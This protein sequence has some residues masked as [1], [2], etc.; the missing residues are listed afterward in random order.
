MIVAWLVIL[1]SRAGIT[2]AIFFLLFPVTIL[3][4]INDP[5]A[6]WAQGHFRSGR[7]CRLDRI[8][9]LVRKTLETSH[10]LR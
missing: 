7:F 1:E 6:S 9:S 2:I 10:A 4:P 8:D 5:E 3:F